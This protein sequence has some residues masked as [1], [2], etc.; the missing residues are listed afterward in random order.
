MKLPLITSLFVTMLIGPL[1]EVVGKQEWLEQ[2]SYTEVNP[3]GSVTLPC[4]VTDKKGDCRWE[5]NSMPVGAY[6]DK[7]EW[8]GDQGAG[9]CSLRISSASTE[10]DSGEW[11]C[12]VTAST[13]MERDTLMSAPAKLVV[14]GKWL[15][16]YV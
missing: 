9:D 4:R 11:V 7:Y 3:G 1:R 5:R 10:Y 12:Q 14:R 15:Y 6:P 16:Q 13:F 8:A 2:P